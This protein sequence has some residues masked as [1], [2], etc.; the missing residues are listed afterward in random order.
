[1]Q[2]SQTQLQHMQGY[3]R[4]EHPRVLPAAATSA[5]RSPLSRSCSAVTAEEAVAEASAASS[6]S[7]LSKS[8]KLAAV[9]GAPAMSPLAT[10]CTM[11]HCP[12]NLL[13]NAAHCGM[14]LAITTWHSGWRRWHQ[15][16]HSKYQVK[17]MTAQLCDL[18]R[19]PLSCLILQTHFGWPQKKVIHYIWHCIARSRYWH[20][21]ACS[22]P[23]PQIHTRVGCP[24][25]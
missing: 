5:E 10:T 8:A 19:T 12:L 14:D 21:C 24:A 1:M 17:C 4:Q 16:K 9:P 2:P 13:A 22:K 7:R 25:L 6:A 18:I 23:D 15:A 20:S 3:V 11:R